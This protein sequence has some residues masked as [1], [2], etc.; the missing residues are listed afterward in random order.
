MWALLVSQGNV[1]VFI[2]ILRYIKIMISKHFLEFNADTFE[3]LVDCQMQLN[4]DLHKSVNN[5][6]V[7][8]L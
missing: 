2:E 6:V 4:D 8:F 7:K 1:P 3:I 5:G